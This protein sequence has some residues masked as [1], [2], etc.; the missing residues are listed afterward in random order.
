[1]AAY[2]RYVNT[3]NTV[4][5]DGTT[6]ATDGSAT[7]AFKTLAE[8]LPLAKPAYLTTAGDTLT[9]ECSGTTADTVQVV[10]DTTWNGF[11]V[12]INGNL[13]GRKYDT[14][15]YRRECGTSAAF[16]SSLD[17]QGTIVAYV[18]RMQIRRPSTG[19]T[20]AYHYLIRARNTAQV[21]IRRSIL[22][23]NDSALEGARC[24][25]S[26]SDSTVHARNTLFLRGGTHA[27]ATGHYVHGSNATGR[28][29]NC[30]FQGISSQAINRSAGAVSVKNCLFTGCAADTNDFT[31][32]TGNNNATT[33]ASGIGTSPRVSQTFTF[34]DTA[35]GDYGLASTDA[36]ARGF[37]AD[38]SADANLAVTDDVEGEA[39]IAPF[40]IGYDQYVA[41]DTTAPTVA[42]AVIPAAGATVV[43]TYTEAGSPPILPL[44]AVTGWSFAASG[45]AVSITDGARTS[46]LVHTFT[47]SRTILSGETVTRSYA[48]GNVSDSATTP[49]LLASFAAQPVTNNST[50]V[51]AD[52]INITTQ[53]AATYA[54]GDTITIVAAAQNA[55]GTTQTDYNPAAVFRLRVRTGPPEISTT[56]AL[57]ADSP[58]N[59]AVALTWVVTT[60]GTYTFGVDD[61]ANTLTDS[62]ASTST[63]VSAATGG[64]LIFG[65]DAMQD[66]L[67]GGVAARRRIQFQAVNSSGTPLTGLTGTPTLSI[68]G[69]AASATGSNAAREIGV[70]FYDVEV[71]DA[72]ITAGDSVRV[73]AFSTANRVVGGLARVV[74]VDVAS[75][76]ATTTETATA[77]WASGTRTLSSFGTLASDTATSVWAAT[78][79]S[80]TTF[81][82]LAA[83]VWAS[84]TRSL[85]DKAGFALTSAEHTSIGAAVAANASFVKLLKQTRPTWKWKAARSG[86]TRVVQ[87]TDETG[88]AVAEATVEYESASSTVIKQLTSLTYL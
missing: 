81:G 77:V 10:T 36:G 21:H 43:V 79:R 63:T 67:K 34:V 25:S 19:A 88:V 87:L 2:T 59:G 82:T 47:L 29:H 32:V 30:T 18:N 80:L 66:I 54:V 42:S 37:G 45:G 3:D 73:I 35:T 85:T 52:R 22:D 62:A 17:F 49:N 24:V 4:S 55:S 75:T 23:Q 15:K 86:A 1:M 14:T 41:A 40:D 48:P 26:E 60:A 27:T 71:T 83:D 33:N 78:A 74:A 65:D 50:A 70:G 13:A 28:F 44:S 12:V 68:N 5:G 20:D 56:Y 72:N 46:D 69:A 9:V 16:Q 53:P 38:L 7:S 8:A 57:D 61:D 58:V 39:R 51:V 84:A 6:N 76:P 11:T 31:N 64:T